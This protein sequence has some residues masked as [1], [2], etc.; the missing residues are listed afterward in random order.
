MELNLG[1]LI[2]L[3][4]ALANF[5]KGIDLSMQAGQQCAQIIGKLEYG[6]NRIQEAAQKQM[7]GSGLSPVA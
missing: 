4:I 5:L 7:A 6:I 1:D 3:E 2:L